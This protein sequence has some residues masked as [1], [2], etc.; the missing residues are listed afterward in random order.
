M[1]G[2]KVLTSAGIG[3]GSFLEDGYNE[4]S[5]FLYNKR[6]LFEDMADP[7]LKCN[8]D[9]N[10]HIIIVLLIWSYIYTGWFHYQ[11]R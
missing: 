2:L 8:K 10:C 11:V 1:V 9:G 6:V 3:G 5:G 4:E 7:Y